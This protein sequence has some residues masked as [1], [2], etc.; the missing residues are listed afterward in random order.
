MKLNLGC[1]KNELPGYDNRDIKAG[2][3]CY[4]LPFADG[5]VEE[6]RASH[7][8]EHLTFREASEALWD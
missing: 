8:L 2:Q 6:V 3:P 1:G 4:P 7:V 5:T